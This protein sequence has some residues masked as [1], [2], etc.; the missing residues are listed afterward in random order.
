VEALLGP[1]SSY[2]AVGG[3]GRRY[4]L[5]YVVGD[6]RDL[7]LLRTWIRDVEVY[8]YKGRAEPERV[9]DL[10]VDMLARVNKLHREPEFYDTLTNNCTTN[11]VQHVNRLR[12]GRIPNDWRV[13][14]PGHSDRLAYQLGLLEID[15]PFE[16]AREH[17]KIN[18]LAQTHA[19]SPEFSQRIRRQ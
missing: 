19:D 11:L 15:G 6:E 8:L 16:Y 13:L 3:A 5:M 17:A 1:A 7:I 9:Q 10:L 12:P 14:M 4:P 2:T 18:T